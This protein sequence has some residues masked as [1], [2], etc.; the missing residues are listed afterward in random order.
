MSGTGAGPH[1]PQGSRVV[2]VGAYDFEHLA[3]LPAVARNLV[4]LREL[5][6]DPRVWG[7]P[8]RNCVVIEQPEHRD[9][10]LDALSD[11]AGAA[12]DL[13]LLY[14]A[15]HGLISPDTEDLLLSLPRCRPDRPYTALPFQDVRHVLRSARRV[16]AKAVLLDCC[17]A[18]RALAGAMGPDAP[19][20]DAMEPGGTGLGGSGEDTTDPKSKSMRPSAP[21]VPQD[22]R[23]A[24]MSRVEGTYVLAAASATRQ[25][26]APIG[27]RYTAFT[28]RLIDILEHGV[29]GGPKALDL[30]TVHTHL[31][32]VLP[33]LGFPPPQQRNDDHGARI[34]LGWN[35]H[36]SAADTTPSLPPHLRELLHAQIIAARNFTYRL[37]D[38]PLDG[39]ATVYVRQQARSAPTT[40]PA[41]PREELR[42]RERHLFR[43]RH[44]EERRKRHFVPVDSTVESTV[45]PV[46]PARAAEETLGL[47]RHVLITGGAGQGKSTLSLQL[48]ASLST[49]YEAQSSRGADAE[50]L[51][52]LRVT[53]GRLAA[54]RS[55]L[56]PR[57]VRILSAELAPHLDRPLPDDLLD[58]LPEGTTCLLIVDGLDEITDPERRRGLVAELAGRVR[59]PDGRFR[60]LITTRPL[61]NDELAPLQHA[62]TGTY[63]LEPFDREQLREFAHR[64]F[65]DH[66]DGPELT[67]GFLRQTEAAGIRDLVRVPLLATVAALVYRKQPGTPLP[68]SRFTLYCDYFTLLADAHLEEVHEQQQT[69]LHRWTP[70][71]AAHRASA[72]FLFE[73]RDELVEHLAVTVV[74]DPAAAT[75]TL[76]DLALDRLDEHGCRPTRRG[77]PEWGSLVTSVLGTAG[78]FTHH[79][80][81]LRFTHYS[82]AEHIAASTRANELPRHF[83]AAEA[84]WTY[85]VHRA[86]DGDLFAH[87]VLAHHAHLHGTGDTILGWLNRGTGDYSALAG[88]LLA[89][90]IPASATHTD[91]FVAHLLLTLSN[92]DRPKSVQNAIR[93]A[94]ILAPEPGVRAALDEYVGGCHR[95]DDLRVEIAQALAIHDPDAALAILRGVLNAENGPSATR[96]A[97]IRAL[98]D[99]GPQHAGE[100]ADLARAVLSSDRA[101]AHVRVDAASI[102]VRPGGEHTTPG[103]EALVAILTAEDA[104]IDDRGQAALALRE[105]DRA[106]IPEAARALRAACAAPGTSASDRRD[107][108]SRLVEL[109]PRLLPDAEAI[110]RSDLTAPHAHP[111]DRYQIAM[112]LAELS[113]DLLPEVVRILRAELIAPDSGAG[114]KEDSA[115]ALARVA[116]EYVLEAVTTLRRLLV[117]PNTS[118]FDRCSIAETLA[119]IDPKHVVEAAAALRAI[120]TDPRTHASWRRL[121]AVNLAKLGPDHVAEAAHVLRTM[122]DAPDVDSGDRLA[123]ATSMADLGPGHVPAAMAA[124]RAVLVASDTDAFLRVAAADALV[125][126]EASPPVEIIE[127]LHRLR[128]DPGSLHGVHIRAARAL[129]RLSSEETT[130]SVAALRSIIADPDI[131]D[132]FRL[133]AIQ[134]LQGLG[135][136]YLSQVATFARAIVE[137]PDVHASLKADAARVLSVQGRRFVGE[138]VDVYRAVLA[139]PDSTARGCAEAALQ[140]SYLGWDYRHEVATVLRSIADSTWANPEERVWAAGLLDSVGQGYI[141]EAATRLRTL[142]L[143]SETAPRTRTAA[144]SRLGGLGDGCAS[145]AASL[146]RAVIDETHAD[147]A[148]RIDA[149][150]TLA[151]LG[152]GYTDEAAD[153][154][155]AIVTARDRPANERVD[156][157]RKLLT[158]HAGRTADVAD[159]LR[160]I[161]ATRSDTPA[162]RTLAARALGELGPGYV[163][164]GAEHLRAL[165]A[166]PD[167]PPAARGAA[168]ERLAELGQG[169]R[170]EGIR[171][172]RDLLGSAEAGAG[173]RVDIARRLALLSP[174]HLPEAAEVFRTALA[175]ADT[176]RYTRTRA[177]RLFGELGPRFLDAAAAELRTLLADPTATPA[178]TRRAASALGMLSPRLRAEAAE[179]LRSLPAGGLETG[180][181][182][183]AAA[184]NTYARR[185]VARTLRTFGQGYALRP[186]APADV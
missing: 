47:H 148:A 108:A 13:V 107:G 7:L 8:A 160:S 118:L 93:D 166:A 42:D 154:L 76:L 181:D 48:A 168:A 114:T 52:P 33:E 98:A 138:A 68:G 95:R 61:P 2:L 36:P 26:V 176:S 49:A 115:A 53:A 105:I 147:V 145:E 87:A 11:A 129:A 142:A 84:A 109:D 144:A 122:L 175:R 28:G 91:S 185:A 15:G 32:R 134:T 79:T 143:S 83:D 85:V 137:A 71:S 88:V 92:E 90:G 171:A 86:I 94:A 31:H 21:Q 183:G 57:L 165:I 139:A 63:T 127:V 24:E 169:Y 30:A 43:H 75:R 78:V 46:A 179:A 72:A 44:D 111:Y 149:A 146:L 128:D 39:L 19:R 151:L 140:M 22:A 37:Y 66:A 136:E 77:V 103:V 12:T 80:D 113:P 67:D 120:S 172:L 157:A 159:V 18:G 56:V 101:P 5:L 116:P 135:V 174:L 69:V 9:Q 177:A 25:A 156:A 163:T 17:F 131:L 89:G 74:T 178:A 50:R 16:P 99:L 161:L 58:H 29:P 51:L 130:T 102:C 110:L 133:G 170:T 23:L 54:D 62:A 186:P 106:F 55:A 81:F 121:A 124:L 162:V 153:V 164:E 59:N 73:H 35:R 167:C 132:G 10:V 96:I 126:L 180:S 4:R 6:T 152:P 155:E 38:A 64:W 14:Y 125:R 158:V 173:D 97:A 141:E 20:P 34:V 150:Q 65:H 119:R 41:E 3:P 123:V 112:K 100:A 40:K 70:R 82:F 27:G 182:P 1:D 60:L 104:D 184:P 45:H 117:A